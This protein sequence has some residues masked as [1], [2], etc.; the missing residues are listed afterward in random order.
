MIVKV[1]GIEGQWF[2]IDRV[3][4]CTCQRMV[5]ETFDGWEQLSKKANRSFVDLRPWGENQK[6]K[7]GLWIRLLKDGYQDEMF[8]FCDSEAYLLNDAG[9]TIERL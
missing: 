9:S 5:C 2:F 1:C 3:I 8:L 4:E 7:V 6:T